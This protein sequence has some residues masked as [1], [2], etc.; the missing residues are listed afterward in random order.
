MTVHVYRQKTAYT[1]IKIDETK[2]QFATGTFKNEE[3]IK[4]GILDK[5]QIN[6]AGKGD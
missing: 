3:T 4:T 5:I 6:I 2:S 1:T